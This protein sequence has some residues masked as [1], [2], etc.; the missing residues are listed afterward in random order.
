MWNSKSVAIVLGVLAIGT[1]VAVA[2]VPRVTSHRF[3]DHPVVAP[4]KLGDSEI[5]CGLRGE[6]GKALFGVEAGQTSPEADP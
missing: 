5:C 1:A 4:L 6:T 2:V 3:H